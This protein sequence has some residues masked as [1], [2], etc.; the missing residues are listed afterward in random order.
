M[1]CVVV[2][3][4]TFHHAQAGRSST[5]TGCPSG[6]MFSDASCSGLLSIWAIAWNQKLTSTP[7]TF[8]RWYM[9]ALQNILRHIFITCAASMEFRLLMLVMS[10]CR[11][12]KVACTMSSSGLRASFCLYSYRLATL[13]KARSALYIRR[14]SG[15]WIHVRIV[16]I[17]EGHLLHKRQEQV[18]VLSDGKL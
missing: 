16:G 10:C 9:V 15:L 13:R 17:S 12:G 6:S 5:S 1:Y 7:C 4:R 18:T 3:K 2:A 11:A 14:T 8:G